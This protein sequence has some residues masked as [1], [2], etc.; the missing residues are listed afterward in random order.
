MNTISG[1]AQLFFSFVWYLP[2]VRKSVTYVYKKIIQL[3]IPQVQK[4]AHGESLSKTT[5]Q[6]QLLYFKV[7]S[8]YHD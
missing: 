7:L 4:A 6:Q 1:I 8:Y 5:L 2:L 3:S